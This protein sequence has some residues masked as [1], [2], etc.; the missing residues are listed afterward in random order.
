MTSKVGSEYTKN[1]RITL[2][3]DV[4]ERDQALVRSKNDLMD[5]V[6]KEYYSGELEKYSVVSGVSV[7][8][9]Y[10]DSSNIWTVEYIVYFVVQ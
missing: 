7:T 4:T 6:D 8:A 2:S 1:Y 3:E 5:L 9:V 10:R